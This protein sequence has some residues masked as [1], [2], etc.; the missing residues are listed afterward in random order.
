MQIDI[1]DINI[2]VINKSGKG[3]HHQFSK[4][5]G[6]KPDILDSVGF[7]YIVGACR[8]CSVT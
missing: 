6:L 1:V 5:N 7:W 3:T 8:P 4:S 2:T